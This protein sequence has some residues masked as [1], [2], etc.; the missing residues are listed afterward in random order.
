MKVTYMKR[1]L[2]VLLL[3]FVFSGC[4]QIDSLKSK[5]SKNNDVIVTEPVDP[6]EQPS[7]LINY[8]MFQYSGTLDNVIGTDSSG[9]VLLGYN[10]GKFNL[11]AEFENL[12]EPGEN[13]F[14]E[15]WLVKNSPP[16]LIT[17]GPL[18]KNEKGDV[19]IYSSDEDYTNFD[20]YVLTI[21]PTDDGE[22]GKPNPLPA[23]HI[24][25]GGFELFQ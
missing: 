2:F 14:Y 9:T 15:G 5:F 24:L 11:E 19:N 4:T 7:E 6:L 16:S 21:E 22:D 23:K 20:I 17:T 13:F 1:L 25:E 12:P 8:D 3:G 18:E 10:D